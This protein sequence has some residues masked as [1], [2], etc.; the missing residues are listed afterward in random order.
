MA[1]NNNTNNP[2]PK[3]QPVGPNKNSNAVITPSTMFSPTGTA[4]SNPFDNSGLPDMPALGL[5]MQSQEQAAG[6]IDKAGSTNPPASAEK[7]DPS[8]KDAKV[9]A[10]RRNAVSE[11]FEEEVRRLMYLAGLNGQ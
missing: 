2:T 3:P 7:V 6:P 4:F 9:T 8:K 5:A 1:Y 10:Q 11:S